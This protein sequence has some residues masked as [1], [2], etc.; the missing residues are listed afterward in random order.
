MTVIAKPI[1]AEALNEELAS[2]PLPAFLCIAIWLALSA[3]LWQGVLGVA[4]LFA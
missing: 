1:A 3:L 4:A 2:E